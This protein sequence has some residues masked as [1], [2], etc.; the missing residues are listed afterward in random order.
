MIKIHWFAVSNPEQKRYPE[1][2]R[3]FGIT[4]EGAVFV[5]AA[6][7]GDSSELGTPSDALCGR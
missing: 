7:A 4:D 2:R 3:S 1:W 5:P 6:M